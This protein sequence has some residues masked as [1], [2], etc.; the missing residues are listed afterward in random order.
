MRKLAVLFLVVSFIVVSFG[1][2]GCGG[3]KQDSGQTSQPAK[4]ESVADLFAKSKGLQ[5]MSYDYVM[6]GKELQMSG[7]MWI[8]G[9]SMRTETTI[10]DKKMI[11]IVDGEA[12]VIYN[13]MPD[14][15]R[16]MKISLDNN[17]N[18]TA[19]AP[20]KYTKESDAGKYKIVETTT[21]DGVKCKVLLFQDADGKASTKMW[22]RED[23]GLPMRVEVTSA[24]AD[25]MVM[26]YKNLKVGPIPAENFKLPAG[27]Q[28][29][30]LGE[31]MKKL[32]KQ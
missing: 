7:K 22:V 4:Q 9:K 1:L 21:Y 8:Q 19:D 28:V 18:K 17:N 5:G 30:D 25:K 14:Q 12:K 6:T 16:A 20:D 23:Y 31:M 3:G 27:V 32:P 13:Y 24:N 10:Q 26:E 11:S 15:N 2:T 29:V